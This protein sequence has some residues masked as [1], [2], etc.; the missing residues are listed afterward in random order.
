MGECEIVI[1]IPFLCQSAIWVKEERIIENLSLLAERGHA[2]ALGCFL[3]TQ[4][5]HTVIGEGAEGVE[6]Y[7]CS[8]SR[9][10]WSLMVGGP[11]PNLRNIK[12]A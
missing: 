11:I 7:Y 12:N 8:G 5:V 6:R 9:E 4:W 2:R 3:G 10:R 1:L